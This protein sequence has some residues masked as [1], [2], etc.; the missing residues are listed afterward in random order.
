MILDAFPR[1]QFKGY[2]I[3]TLAYL[4]RI[5]PQV[6]YDNF[7]SGFG[8]EYTPGYNVTGKRIVDAVD[9]APMPDRPS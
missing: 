9:A 2:F 3:D 6:T 5:K 4:C 8:E 7:M 1:E